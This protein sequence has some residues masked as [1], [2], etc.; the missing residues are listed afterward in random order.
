M[1]NHDLLLLCVSPVMEPRLTAAVS[2]LAN[3]VAV[4]ALRSDLE[5]LADEE[6][7]TRRVKHRSAANDAVLR[8]TAQFPSDVR[9]YVN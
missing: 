2:V 9:Q 5:S 1:Y 4:A 3:D 8:Q 7:E 6:A